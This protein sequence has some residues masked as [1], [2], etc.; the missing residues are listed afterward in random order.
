MDL[1]SSKCVFLEHLDAGEDDGVVG[2][3]RNLIYLSMYDNHIC[4]E[5]LECKI[6][7]LCKD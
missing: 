7:V 2:V 1:C 3:C 4:D 5:E 6:I